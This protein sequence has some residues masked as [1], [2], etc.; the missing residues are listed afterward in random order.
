M[1]SQ[2][3]KDFDDDEHRWLKYNTDQGKTAI[4][5]N[6]QQQMVKTMGWKKAQGTTDQD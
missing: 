6:L 2:L 3:L 1:Q 5:F 4:I